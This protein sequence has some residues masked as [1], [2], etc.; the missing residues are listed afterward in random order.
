MVHLMLLDIG[1]V[2]EIDILFISGVRVTIADIPHAYN[3]LVFKAKE[4]HTG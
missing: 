2:V 1:F 3:S 4:Q